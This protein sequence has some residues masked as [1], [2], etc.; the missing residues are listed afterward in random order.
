VTST[1]RVEVPTMTS[2]RKTIHMSSSSEPSTAARAAATPAGARTV[3]YVLHH[4]ISG[5]PRIPYHHT[6]LT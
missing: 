1:T 6:R 2:V 5:A 3:G 4:G